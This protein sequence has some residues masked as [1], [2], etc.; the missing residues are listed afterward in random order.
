MVFNSTNKTNNSLILMNG[1][2]DERFYLV[3][4]SNWTYDSIYLFLISPWSF[5]NFWLNIISLFIL[6]RIKENSKSAKLYTYLKVYIADCAFMSFLGSFIF[7][8]YS[9]RYF[10]FALGFV[11]RVLRCQIYNSL[12]T[13]LYFYSN[14]LDIFI[15]FERLS[16]LSLYSASFFNRTPPLIL[17]LTGFFG[18]LIFNAPS[19]LWNFVQS[20]EEFYGKARDLANLDKFSYCGKT[21]FIKSNLGGILTLLMIIVRDLITLILEIIFDILSIYYYVNFMK[22]KR[23][24][25][26][27]NNQNHNQNNDHNS[28]NQNVHKLSWS[29]MNL[30][31]MTIT[32]ST[33]SLASHLMTASTTFF[34]TFFRT[35]YEST[36]LIFLI[37]STVNTTKYFSNFFILYFFN[38]NFKNVLSKK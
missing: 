11:G 22:K 29:D 18:C 6:F 34:L 27:S 26:M 16:Q 33:I 8:T 36:S 7:C 10:S 28:N 15:T 32:L 12:T 35:N 24:I 14:V 9:P 19:F 21:D 17:C 2:F 5:V 1:D 13:F 3:I 20:D 4:G 23:Q 38:R 37:C 25:S 30:F 31:A